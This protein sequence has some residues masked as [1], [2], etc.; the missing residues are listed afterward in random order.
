[1]GSPVRV[2]KMNVFLG[3]VFLDS[4]LP[5]KFVFIPFVSIENKI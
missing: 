1:M 2:R 4:Y 3:H 5:L